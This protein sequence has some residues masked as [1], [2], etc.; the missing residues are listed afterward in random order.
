MGL[1]LALVISIGVGNIVSLKFFSY[2]KN[3]DTESIHTLSSVIYSEEIV[4]EEQAKC[5]NKKPVAYPYGFVLIWR[6]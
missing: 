4:A 3:I 5:L 2:Q 1:Q 6:D